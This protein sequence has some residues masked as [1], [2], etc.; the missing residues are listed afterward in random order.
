[1]KIGC[2]TVLFRKF[3]LE[4]SLAA[5]REIGL[6]EKIAYSFD[7]HSPKHHGGIND[8]VHI[9]YN[10]VSDTERYDFFSR[11]LASKITPDAIPYDPADNWPADIGWNQSVNANFVRFMQKKHPECHEL[12]LVVETPYFGFP[13]GSTVT[14]RDTMYTFG[15]CFIGAVRDYMKL[16]DEGKR[17]L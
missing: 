6:R 2:G 11:I 9:P 5:I 17:P 3:D 8:R 1:M 16:A 4:R 10:F 13:D 15:Q 14:N 7:F 12:A